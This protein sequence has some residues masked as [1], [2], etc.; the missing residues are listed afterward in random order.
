MVRR[1]IGLSWALK[2]AKHIAWNEMHSLDDIIV[3]T[4]HGKPVL[5]IHH[6]S[7]ETVAWYKQHNASAASDKHW[8]FF[9]DM[10]GKS[11]STP[12]PEPE[13]ALPIV[14]HDPYVL[15]ELARAFADITDEVVKRRVTSGNEYWF[16]GDGRS[17]SA[18]WN[19]NN[20]RLEPIVVLPRL[21]NSQ[22]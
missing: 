21:N 19:A 22:E 3:C 7:D 9:L 18:R 12:V 10:R 15:A 4:H 20:N 8:Q 17:I 14:Q 2:Q 1:L 6:L 16:Q 11:S 5:E 13:V